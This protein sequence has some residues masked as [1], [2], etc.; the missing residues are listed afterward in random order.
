MSESTPL[1]SSTLSGSVPVP[2]EPTADNGAAA[3]IML[4]NSKFVVVAVI[5]NESAVRAL[6]IERLSSESPRLSSAPGTPVKNAICF[7]PSLRAVPFTMLTFVNLSSGKIIP[8]TKSI[9]Q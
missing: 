6:S 9:G 4:P 1:M 7:E 3:S 2:I 5:V 8:P